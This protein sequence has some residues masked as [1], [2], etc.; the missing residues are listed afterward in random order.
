M[1]TEQQSQVTVAQRIFCPVQP[2]STRS[3]YKNVSL[4]LQGRNL[5]FDLNMNLNLNLAGRKDAG[6]DWREVGDRACHKAVNHKPQDVKKNMHDRRT[7]RL[8]GRHTRWASVNKMF[9]LM[10]VVLA[11]QALNT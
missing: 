5:N 8:H 7:S 1:D 4:N 11:M 2:V 3:A 9:L 10:H 6:K